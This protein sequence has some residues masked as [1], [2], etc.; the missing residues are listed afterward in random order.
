MSILA[1]LAGL[2]LV[3]AALPGLLLH[4]SKLLGAR[5]PV[6]FATPFLILP[7]YFLYSLGVREPFVESGGGVAWL[8]LIGIVLMLLL[9]GALLFGLGYFLRLHKS[10]SG[11]LRR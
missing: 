4:I 5:T 2:V 10:R 3:V 6:E 11:R 8:T 1:R 9:P 7:G